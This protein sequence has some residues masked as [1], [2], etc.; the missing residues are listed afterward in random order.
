[1]TPPLVAE[2]LGLRGDCRVQGV[3]P[4]TR[5]SEKGVLI[6]NCSLLGGQ[7][8]FRVVSGLA[9]LASV[10]LLCS[11]TLPAVLVGLLGGFQELHLHSDG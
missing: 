4:H 1:M 6:L 9:H 2:N 8:L 3:A 7:V 11:S 5:L 10:A